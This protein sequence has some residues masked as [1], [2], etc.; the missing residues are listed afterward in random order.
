MD[1][2]EAVGHLVMVRD[3]RLRAKRRRHH[4]PVD[5]LLFLEVKGL[6]IERSLMVNQMILS[7]WSV[8]WLHSD[9]LFFERHMGGLHWFLES[10]LGLRSPISL[11]WS[12]AVITLRT[13]SPLVALIHGFVCIQI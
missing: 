13:L 8:K 6:C 7:I 4:G 10:N 2:V 12:S 3:H 9:L 11:P 5:V 1:L